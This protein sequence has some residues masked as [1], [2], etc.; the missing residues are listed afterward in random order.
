MP[1]PPAPPEPFAGP[2]PA[3]PPVF[4]VPLP[5]VPEK[6]DRPL[7]PPPVPPEQLDCLLN[8]YFRVPVHTVLT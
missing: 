6:A 5:P 4:T 7:P 3:P 2:P 8:F 1:E